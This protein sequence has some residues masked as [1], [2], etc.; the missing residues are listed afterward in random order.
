MS[1]Q[2][3]SAEAGYV[4]ALRFRWL[5]PAYD[6]VVRYTTREATFK[7]AL[8]DQAR[9]QSGHT[10]LDL[11]CGTGTLTITAK[12]RV[13]GAQ[14]FGLDGDPQILEIARAKAR[15]AGASI[16]FGDALSHSMPYTDASFDRVLCS[17]FF[18]HLST[19][20]K[21]R[22]LR[23]ICRVLKPGGE[24]HIADWG[25]AANPLMRAAFIGIQVLDGF[26]NTSDNIRGLLPQFM[27]EADLVDV[28]ETR[29]F[30]TMWGTLSLYKAVRYR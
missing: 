15:R 7:S 24:L 12:Q 3:R 21:H 11:A 28:A 20:D 10:V 1:D 29:R 27:R 30:S 18:H 26:T 5:T 8:L 23:E 9:I 22:T 6:L 14:V 4:P 17:L 2:G 16:Q 25:A 19:S 13:S